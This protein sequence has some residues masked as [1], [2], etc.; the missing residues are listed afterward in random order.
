LVKLQISGTNAIKQKLD[1]SL[2]PW[3]RKQTSSLV[4]N[5]KENT[6]RKIQF[7]EKVLSCMSLNGLKDSEWDVKTL[8][9]IKSMGG[10]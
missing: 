1:S 10:C 8:K 2:L 7:M 9:M 6:C 5:S 4:S 3:T